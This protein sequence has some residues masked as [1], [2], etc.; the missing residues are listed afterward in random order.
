M[1][2]IVGV[3]GC[4]SGWIAISRDLTNGRLEARVLKHIEEI[5]SF[6]DIVAAT[7]DIPIGLTDSGPRTCDQEARKHLPGKTSS[8]FP[9]PIRAVLNAS[10]YAEARETSTRIQSKS[11]SAQAWALIPKIREVDDYLRADKTRQNWLREIHPE[12]VFAAMN[13]GQ[14]ILANKKTPHGQAARAAILRTA[15]SNEIDAL[16]TRLPEGQYAFDDLYDS[17][18]A[19]WTAERIAKRNAESVPR[20]PPLDSEGLRMEMLV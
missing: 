20:E 12:L 18:A 11:L 3:D 16:M 1:P 15:Y 7:I 13:G 19:L 6:P 14:P 17:L 8:V 5:E 10:S 4:K 9:A 2:N